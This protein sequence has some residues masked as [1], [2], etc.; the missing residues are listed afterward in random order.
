ML[1]LDRRMPVGITD[2][3][4]TFEPKIFKQD[5]G[6]ISR[7]QYAQACQDPLTGVRSSWAKV[8]V[9]TLFRLCAVFFL[10]FSEKKKQW[11]YKWYSGN[12]FTA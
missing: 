4:K 3:G 1:T 9:L 6:A 11:K 2:G 10:Y 5:D 12:H 7:Y 8:C